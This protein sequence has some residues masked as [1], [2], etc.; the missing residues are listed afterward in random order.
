[1]KNYIGNCAQIIDWPS[2]LHSVQNSKPAYQGPR[3][4]KGQDL[5]GIAEISSSWEKAGYK[6]LSEGGTIG[7]DMCVPEVNFDRKI[8]DQFAD[9]VNVDPLSCWVSVIHQ[10][11]HAPWHWD[12]QDNE[13]DLKKIGNIERFHCHMEDTFPG[14]VLIVE[15][16]LFYNAKQGDVYKWPDRNAWHAGSNCGQRPKYIFNFFGKSLI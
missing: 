11:C 7:W 4:K 9:Y 8:V 15:N 6:L 10:G 2:V 5:P 3:H 16:D 1:M 13:E 12:T 14:H